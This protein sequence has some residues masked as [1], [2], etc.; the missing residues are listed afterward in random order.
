MEK[1][2]ATHYSILAWKIPWTEEPGGPQSMEMQRVGHNWVH[3]FMFLPTN[4]SSRLYLLAH[5]FNK[6]PLSFSSVQDQFSSV[7]LLSRV[8][9]FATPW[10]AACQASLSITRSS[11][12]LTSVESVM[13]SSHLILCCLHLLLSPIPPS[14][15]VFSNES[16]LLMRW[17]KYWSFSF[18][19]IPSI[20]HPWVISTLKRKEVS[21]HEKTWEKKSAWKGCKLYDYNMTF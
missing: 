5:S 13:P 21:S 4:H 14:I 7:Q 18:S 19:I 20:Q 11:F 6:Y 16:T 2:M 17:P 8:R 9:L 12:K 15:R 1:E 3:I 10:I